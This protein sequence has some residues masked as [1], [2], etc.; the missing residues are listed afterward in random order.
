[1]LDLAQIIGIVL[2]SAAGATAAGLI[3]R[4]WRLARLGRIGA[5]LLGALVAAPA[6]FLLQNLG[7]GNLGFRPGLGMMDW[8]PVVSSVIVGV[9]CATLFATAVGL[10]RVGGRSQRRR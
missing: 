7:A 1:M 2:A 9:V 4:A 8:P 6:A 10:M 3:A 5:P